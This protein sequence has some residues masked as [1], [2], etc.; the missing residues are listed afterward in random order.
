MFRLR[1][2]GVIRTALVVGT[3]YLIVIGAF[4]PLVVLVKL[5][6]PGSWPG[7]DASILLIGGIA[8]ALLYSV[9]GGVF[10]A[11]A[12][13]I[14]NLAARWVG[15]IEVQVEAVQ[16]PPAV[17]SWGPT[18]GSTPPSATTPSATPTEQG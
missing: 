9:M 18:Y 12:C 14:Y 8:V 5:A 6:V 16:P 2:F 15:G 11:L 7:T 13:A 17:P 4:I 10:T 3:M 1:R